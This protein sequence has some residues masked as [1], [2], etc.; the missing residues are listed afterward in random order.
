[1]K[2][3]K[4]GIYP[5]DVQYLDLPTGSKIIHVGIKESNICIWCEVPNPDKLSDTEQRY[6]RIF[7]TG[8]EIDNKLNLKF[9]GT[10]FQGE[11]YVWHIYEEIKKNGNLKV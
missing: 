5:L 11:Y 9:L 7:G 1:M 2:I 3:F 10:V 8:H 6:I 4:Y